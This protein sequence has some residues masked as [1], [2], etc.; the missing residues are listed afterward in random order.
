MEVKFEYLFY[1]LLLLKDSYSI[2][3][4]HLRSIIN[5][6]LYAE[7]SIMYL[8]INYK[9]ASLLNALLDDVANLYKIKILFSRD[10]S[11]LPI[12]IVPSVF[13]NQ[14]GDACTIELGESETILAMC[15]FALINPGSYKIL[16]LHSKGATNPDIRSG[17]EVQIKK[18]AE[19]MN[20][21]IPQTRETANFLI[22]SCICHY[23][24]KWRI[25]AQALESCN[26][27]Y[28]IWNVFACNS[29][30]LRQFNLG[31]WLNPANVQRFSNQRLTT[32]SDRHVFAGFPIKLESILKQ[33]D[34]LAISH[35]FNKP[36]L[37]LFN[38]LY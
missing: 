33:A 1:H 12:S 29:A 21:A 25:L 24:S 37:Q 20:Y 35:Y 16:F 30:F 14:V 27:H 23:I 4:G 38:N 13:L 9:D 28:L 2:F 19:A 6:G 36:Y 11:K 17:Q 10:I 18:I 26:Y 5:S 15:K 7:C 22:D 31:A 8:G 32:I 3:R 34:I